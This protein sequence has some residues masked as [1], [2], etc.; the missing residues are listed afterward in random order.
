MRMVMVLMNQF[1]ELFDNQM[2]SKNIE[3]PNMN[4]NCHARVR[5][6]WRAQVAPRLHTA[7]KDWSASGLSCASMPNRKIGRLYTGAT[8][9]LVT[10]DMACGTCS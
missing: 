6:W 3:P 5:M 10:K 2:T 8:N 1:W 7:F 4:V 9:A